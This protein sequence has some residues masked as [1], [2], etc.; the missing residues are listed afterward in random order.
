[1]DPLIGGLAI[2]GATTAANNGI[3]AMFA[4]SEQKQYEKNLYRNFELSQQAQRNSA[5]NMVEGFRE[6]GL[7][8]ALAAGANFSAANVPAAPLQNKASH[9]MDMAAMFQATKQLELLDAEKNAANAQAA[10]SKADADKTNIE[11]GRMTREDADVK[12]MMQQAISRVKQMYGH[13]GIDTSSLDEFANY[14][15]SPDTPFNMGSFSAALSSMA[16]ERALS[17]N[18][19]GDIDDALDSMI[20]QHKIKEDIASDITS[21]SHSQRK[22]LSKQVELAIKQLALMQSQIGSNNAKAAL[23]TETVQKVKKEQDYITQETE[24]SKANT[25]NIKNADFRSAYEKGDYLKTLR[26]FGLDGMHSLLNM[27]GLLLK[28][29]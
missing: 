3:Q 2:A 28:N 24:K 16:Y 29:R 20:A 10:K 4:R 11:S 26:I 9:P 15:E 14:L 17:Q 21:M 5:K 23:D 1:M 7:S 13:S 6:A 27:L 18:L 22:L 25:D 8:P 19:S 12:D